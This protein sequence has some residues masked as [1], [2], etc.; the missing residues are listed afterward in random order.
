MS[1]Y[2]DFVASKAL[3][4][5]S[6]GF[7]PDFIHNQMKDFQKA[8]LKYCCRKGRSMAALDTGLGK[9]FLLLSWAQN[10]FNKTG[11]PVICFAPLCVGQQTEKEAERWGI[12]AKYYLEDCDFETPIV[13][14][15]YERIHKFDFSK[16]AG[17]VL[18]ESGIIKG[19]DSKIKKQLMDVATDIEY[20]LC[21]SAT[22]APNDYMEIGAQAEFLGVMS[23]V[24]MLATFFTHDSSEISK[25]TLKGH[26]KVAFWEWMATWAVV[27]KKPSDIG[28]DDAGYDLPPL[29]MIIHT[30]ESDATPGRLVAVEAG[31]LRERLDARRR[32]V[33]VRCQT[34]ADMVNA[35]TESWVVWCHLNDEG[36]FLEKLI[37]G[38]VQ[39]AGRH[40]I[41][42]KERDIFAFTNG[43][44][45]VLISKV[46]IAGYGMN[47]QHCH[48]MAFVGINDSFEEFYQAIRREWRF[49][50]QHPVNVHVAVT[51]EQLSVLR[52]IEKKQ[53]KNDV[54][55]QMMI[56]HM[57]PA[58][59]NEFIGS[60]KT[61]D[62]YQIGDVV[63]SGWTLM[64]GDCVD[65]IKDIPDNSVGFSVF[66]PPFA[67]LYTYSASDRDM[68]NVR[69]HSEFYA[70][71]QFL[72]VELMRVMEPGRNV[73]FHCM[74]LPTSKMRDGVIGLTD[75]RGELI[76]MFISAGFIYHSEV[77]IWKDPV[78]AMQRTKALGLLHKQIKKDS[79]MSRNGIPDYVVTMRKPGVNANPVSQSPEARDVNKW[80]RWASP[81][82][83]DIDQGKTLNRKDILGIPLKKDEDDQKHICPLQLDVIERLV[84]L[85]SNKGDLVLSPFAGIGSEGFQA[86]KMGRRFIGIELKKLYFDQAVRN[87][88]YSVNGG[89]QKSLFDV[90]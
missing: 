14:A 79:L 8:T 12:V 34:I 4:S 67:S 2:S 28:F 56:G 85:W 19:L 15:N 73:S 21:C 7:E 25:W 30:I 22:P 74:N 36:D 89:G 82:W 24:D 55:S 86:I 81:I 45:R 59:A 65:R 53:E 60:T 20:R 87:I 69:S 72:I 41:D 39:V 54:M 6:V 9:T 16:F 23:M 75:F 77:C 26:G 63:G 49:G 18:D 42:K 47:W 66:S 38:S 40:S 29:N 37:P 46:S 31:D 90:D 70:H 62:I 17:I 61:S 33:D 43:H 48:N 68:G 78:I 10:V 64:L 88:S 5:V 52:N 11:K 32:S 76:R 44:V 80:Q 1:A 50:Q 71:F 51:E 35:S 84:G 57:R 3:K 13:I 58:M 83:T 27:I